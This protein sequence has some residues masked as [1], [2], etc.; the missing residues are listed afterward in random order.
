MHLYPNVFPI[1]AFSS[2]R[3]SMF[4]RFLSIAFNGHVLLM[5]FPP[6]STVSSFPSKHDKIVVVGSKK[7]EECCSIFGKSHC[8]T[9]E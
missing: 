1:P 8:G 7:M 6:N 3:C 4:S 9:K 2:C 5:S